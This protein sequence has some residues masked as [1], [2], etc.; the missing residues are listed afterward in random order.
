MTALANRKIPCAI[1]ATPQFTV[2]QRDTEQRTQWRSGQFIGRV[3]HY[4]RLPDT[5]SQEELFTVA[6]VY[7]PGADSR[8]VR[9]LA[10]TAKIS[11]RGLGL[12]EFVSQRA[13][14]EVERAGRKTITAADLARVI[15]SQA[16]PTD[17]ILSELVGQALKASPT[18]VRGKAP[19][20]GVKPSGG[21]STAGSSDS[22]AVGLR[23]VRPAGMEAP[24]RSARVGQLVAA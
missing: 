6:Q 3:A 16:L 5:L 20:R 13:R 23:A 14:F 7:L 10:Q 19:R 17:G 9:A 12:L 8:M 2:S 18:P 4:E 21:D 22:P 1:V 24:S 15:K 11:R